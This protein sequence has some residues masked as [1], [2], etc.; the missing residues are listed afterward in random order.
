MIDARTAPRDKREWDVVSCLREMY[1]KEYIH[2]RDTARSIAMALQYGI[3]IRNLNV[4]L[5]EVWNSDE[6]FRAN[7][8]QVLRRLRRREYPLDLKWRYVGE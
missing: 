7:C 3:R 4:D 1:L 5:V 6:G 8:K 2:R